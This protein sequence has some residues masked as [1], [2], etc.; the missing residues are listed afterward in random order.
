MLTIK[1]D[2]N[3]FLTTKYYLERKYNL[4]IQVISRVIIFS[5]FKLSEDHNLFQIFLLI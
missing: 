2:L 4:S 3:K 5:I 1:T